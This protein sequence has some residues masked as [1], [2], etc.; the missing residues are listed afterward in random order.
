[1]NK[2]FFKRILAYLIDC[3]ILFFAMIVVNLF[4]PISGNVNELNT[5]LS[6]VMNKYMA[7]EISIEE[8][9]EESEDI[10]YDLTKATYI[11]SIAGIVVYILYFVVYQAYNNG[12]TLGKRWLKIQVVKNDGSAVDMNNLLVRGLIPYGLLVNFI[13]VIAI[14]FFSKNMFL[15]ISH[16]LG[17]IHNIVIFVTIIMMMIKSRGIHDYLSKTK[18]EEI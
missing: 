9:T 8:F 13:L 1:M 3:F 12:Q 11:S 2:L 4:I 6:D 15:N 5:R 16:I 18:V 14:M 10:S 7:E 17:N